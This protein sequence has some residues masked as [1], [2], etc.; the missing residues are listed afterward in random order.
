MFGEGYNRATQAL[1][2]VLAKPPFEATREPS[3]DGGVLWS[4][5]S[6]AGGTKEPGH[7]RPVLRARIGGER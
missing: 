6:H 1:S 2:P 5:V 7:V 4:T 3:P